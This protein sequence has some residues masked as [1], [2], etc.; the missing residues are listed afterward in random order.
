MSTRL[1]RRD[2]VRAFPLV[3]MGSAIGGLGRFL[4]GCSEEEPG[5]PIRGG[6]GTPYTPVP[7]TDQDEFVPPNGAPPTNAGD[8]PPTLPVQTWEAR[9]RQ[10]EEEQTRIYGPVFTR[11]A[12]GSMAGKENSHEPQVTKM[13]EGGYKKVVIL[14]A[15]VM[16]KNAL[17][18][19]AYDAGVVDS[20]MRDAATDAAA[21]AGD[22]GPRMDAA[23]PVEGGSLPVHYITTMYLRAMVGGKDTVVG[24]WE[25]ASTDPAPPSV[26][27]TLPPGITEV[28]AYEWCTLHGLWKASPLAI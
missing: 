16:G 9:A 8:L 5:G 27:F 17:D 2:I 22:A 28:V 6:G 14:V 3:L 1:N 21:D 24:L 4:A 10:L 11:A 26:K 19:G 18:A 23:A 13:E 15:H 7:P 20:G 25:F 12:P